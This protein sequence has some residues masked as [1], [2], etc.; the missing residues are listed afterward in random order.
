[1]T[2]HPLYFLLYLLLATF[3]FVLQAQSQTLSYHGRIVDGITNV[4]VSGVRNF[5]IQI[6]TPAGLADNCLMYEESQ[7]KT[8]VN[9]VFVIRLNDG[10][11]TRLD[12][13]APVYTLQQIFSNKNSFGSFSFAGARCTSASP[14]TY[15]PSAADGRRVYIYFE[16]P[17]APGIWE[18]LPTQTVSYVPAAIEA[19]NV[20]GFP[21]E[22]LLRVVDGSGNPSTLPSPL[23]EAQYTALLNVAS[24]SVVNSL[25]GLN[26]AVSAVAGTAG[27]DFNIVAAGATVTFNI[28]TA[29]S[30]NRG[31]LSPADWTTFN[32]KMPNTGAAVVSALGYTPLDPANNLS[33]LTNATTARGNLGLGSV[34]TLNVPA[35]PA[36]AA[37]ATEAVRGDDPRLT[38]AITAGS[39]ASGD[40]TGTY[41]NPTVATVGGRTAAQINTSVTDTL[42][43][44]NANTA[45]TIVKRD[46]GGN[47]SLT[48]ASA[49][50]FTGNNFY[51]YNTGNANRVQL[52]APTP[53]SGDYTFALPPNG[54]SPG[55][56]LG[57]DGAGNTTWI[58]P[59]ST[60]VTAVTASAPLASS[61]GFMPNI[62][63]TRS[64]ATT[65]GYLASTDFTTFAAKQSTDLSTG[66][67]WV[68]NGSN[69][70]APQ[71]LNISNIRSTVAGAWFQGAACPSGQ[72]LTYSAIT[73]AVTCQAYTLTGSQVATSLSG[74][75]SGDVTMSSDGT[76]VIGANRITN[77]MIND[78]AWAK[79]TSRPNTIAG[80]G[81]ID[82]VL[83]NAGGIATMEAS[84]DATRGAAGNP[85]RV[86][87]SSDTGEI[88][89][90]NGA[91]WVR[92]GSN[93]GLGGTV[94]NVSA[95]APLSVV[96]PTT[97]PTISISRANG[98]TDGYLASTDWTTF[99]NKL[100]N[101][102][103]NGSMWIGNGTNVP[104]AVTMS[105]DA[106]IS[107][108]GVLTLA[109]V[110]SAGT[111]TKVTVNAKGLVTSATNINSSDVTT[112]LGY[113]PVN[114]AGDTMTGALNM[115]GQN[116]TNT[117]V[118]EMAT[119]GNIQVSNRAADPGALGP[120]DAGRFWYNSTTNELKYWNGS[121]VQ[122][123]GTIA[124]VVTGVN[125]LTGN[126][127]IQ[128][129]SAG[130]DFNIA[131]ASPNVTINIPTS[132]AT[133]RGLLTS[134]D[135]SNFNSKQAGS[136]ELTGLAGL[137]TTGFVRRTG[138]GTY[139]TTS[140]IDITTMIT[141]ILPIVNGG[142]GASTATGA[143]NNL[144]PNQTGNAGRFLRT[145]GT[146][147]TWTVAVTSVGA[148][149]PLS[150]TGAGTAT[151]L[152]SISQAD[153]VTDGYIIAAD[154]NK[155]NNKMSA[156]FS[157]VSGTLGIA[158]GGTGAT[159]A[160]AARTNLGLG[161]GDSPTFTGLTLSGVNGN[162]LVKSNGSGVLSNATSTDVTGL[163][164]FTP[165]RVNTVTVGTGMTSGG[166]SSDVTIGLNT[167]LQGLSALASNGFVRRTGAGTYSSV[168][169][170]DLTSQVTGTLPISM[171]GTGQTTA[172]NALNALLPS[173]TGN[174]GRVLSTDGTNVS[175]AVLPTNVTNVTAS[176]PLSS[177]GGSTPNISMTR[178]TASV[179]GYLASTDFTLFSNKMST[180]FSNATGTLSVAR[181]GTGTGTAPT[182]GQ[183]LIG[184]GTGYTLAG[185]TGTSNQITVTTG[186]GSITL[187]TPQNIHTGASPTF[188]GLTLSGVNGNTLVKSDGSGVLSN[189][190]SAD[191]T[192]LLGYT[193]GT[194]T[195]V[196]VGTGMTGGGSSGAL[197]VGVNT[198]LQGLSGLA[199]NGFIRRTAAGTY[200]AVASIDLTSQVTGTLPVANG[201]TGLVTPG[202]ANNILASN[203]LGAWTS[204]T[205]DGADIVDKS[206]AQTISGAKTMSGNL[207]MSSPTALFRLRDTGAN[208]VSFRAPAT[209]GTSYTLTMPTQAPNVSGQVLAASTDGTMAWVTA[210]TGTVGV[211]SGGTGL[212]SGTSGGIPYFNSATTMAS[213]AAL[214]ANGVVLGGGAGGAPTSTA[215]GAA[216]SVLRVP[217]GGGAP[218]FG[219][220]DLTSTAAVTGSLPVANGGT[221]AATLTAGS[222]VVGNGTSAVN[223]L[224]AG[225]TGNVIYAT[226]AAAWASGTPTQ[227]G[228]VAQN[229]NSF[230]TAMTVGTSDANTLN[231]ETA[232]T[233][234]MSF[235]TSGAVQ[236]NG[237]M[238]SQV[239]TS[240]AATPLTWDANTSNIMRWTTNT[241]TI[242]A[243]IRNMKPGATY[244][245]VVSGTGTGTTT[246][247]CF[248]DNGVTSLPNSFIPANGNRVTG[249]RNKTVY[250][251]MSDGENCL[252]T[253]ITG[254]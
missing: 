109:T 47:I 119:N 252:I 179:D 111:Y 49:T 88:W 163:L 181:G 207:T 39:A 85:G 104:T 19:I 84:A 114:R 137:S 46:A 89:Y 196:T 67:V 38:G 14:F 157:N 108:T 242:T 30:A 146:N 159:T 131:T 87:V 126:V 197:S 13:T 9:G 193:P 64:N 145:D 248:S 97:T 80:Y 74:I 18:P 91:T 98:T 21:I 138:A 254:F 228:L 212:T 162:T 247:N 153:A 54:G 15:S 10:S 171:G 151:P 229:G 6:R 150:I 191:I 78:V 124:G 77:S 219:A 127:T 99:N 34:A 130:T 11:G 83:I 41:P 68:G 60:S 35:A 240:S 116:L 42:A 81:I 125:G 155:F 246:I 144:L 57:T 65:D 48:G 188:T 139:S 238:W 216:N 173:Q 128:T 233:T 58:N 147:A 169:S 245:L 102:L 69:V 217:A 120:A 16:D 226:G 198:E 132:S 183:L 178:S 136:T 237:Q 142:T 40:L 5:R 29:S 94:T 231:L 241:A 220:I 214:T 43:A 225:T 165:G 115:G 93:S 195:S 32:N 140:S 166:T 199:S 61:G 251:L 236:V 177:T 172:N 250:S 243:N 52:V 161:T 232:N 154:W 190:T 176:A 129:G 168:A 211:T 86:F 8:L 82:A 244:Q 12:A 149:A 235:D 23:S 37:G 174:A 51:I 203:G 156:D 45:S 17:A 25:N 27:T 222:L 194:I 184:N 66:M 180:D 202:A 239:A 158:N 33:E 135:W 164:G 62:S 201:G 71:F 141:G 253:W 22:S 55:Y 148:S 205:A 206:N 152:V 103:A 26:G 175:W 204:S 31:L 79:V 50:N 72:M 143:L 90:D 189:A 36:T 59:S 63:I 106:T 234:R 7:T 186:A 20:S 112:A 117:G 44:T 218:V 210:L 187:A 208:T 100:N 24:G 110:T 1:M 3:G 224:T 133:N 200:S 96:S 122:T 227:A 53:M 230:G 167:E 113:T 2:R 221:G 70:A 95:N 76:T 160:S 223:F 249:T 209:V 121:S 182:N 101:S 170:I 134:S 73:D 215:A 185:L 92:V 123:L 28:P 56:V 4:G 105:G 107:N 192:G 118:I 75:M 213:S